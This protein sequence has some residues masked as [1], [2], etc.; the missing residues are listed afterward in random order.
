MAIAVVCGGLFSIQACCKVYCEKEFMEIRFINFDSSEVDTF[1]LSLYEPNGQF[2][3]RIDSFYT[4]LYHYNND[5]IGYGF[6]YPNIDL[7]KHMEFK[8]PGPNRVFRITDIDTRKESCPCGPG[9]SKAVKAYTV[10][11]AKQNQWYVD[12]RK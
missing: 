2:N 8:L 9:S 1:L 3:Q 5:T 4:Y 6:T 11:G 7:S 10:N 12:L